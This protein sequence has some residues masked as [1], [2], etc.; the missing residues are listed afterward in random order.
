MI[1][2]ADEAAATI[3]ARTP[4]QPRI[5]VILGSGLGAFARSL[6]RPVTVPYAKIPH[7]RTVSVPGHRGDLVIGTLQKVPLMA[8]AGRPHL[9]EGYSAEEIAFPVRLAARLGARMIVVTNAAGSVNVNYKPGELMLLTDHINLTGASP[10]MG[11]HDPSLGDRFLDMSDAYDPEL[12]EIAEKAAWK[13]GVAVRKGVYLGLT[14]PSYETPAE[15]KMA[16]T[17]GADAVGMSTVLEVIAARQMRLRVLGI[18]C[19]ANMAAGVSKRKLD[20]D[21][22]LQA[23]ESANAALS[24][25]LAAVIHEAAPRLGDE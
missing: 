24:D 3:R 15:V 4:L 7:F 11:L 10:L 19:L 21:E 20:H 9:Y 6:E 22:V 17:I 5:A 2:K 12:L 1:A 13:V 18:S 8:F 25:L 16:R 23:G 14:G